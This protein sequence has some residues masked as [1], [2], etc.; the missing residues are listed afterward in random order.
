[1]QGITEVTTAGSRA[2][3]SE[4]T[5]VPADDPAQASWFLG[6][7]LNAHSI[8]GVEELRHLVDQRLSGTQARVARAEAELA[9]QL[10][11]ELDGH[12]RAADEE[13]IEQT[14][15]LRLAAGLPL[16][17]E[18]RVGRLRQQT[19]DLRAVSS[20]RAEADGAVAE[21]ER[22]LQQ[23]A[24]GAPLTADVE[25][26]REASH[27]IA[28]AE[29]AA[30]AAQA[31]LGTA[32]KGVRPEQRI[33]LRAAGKRAYQADLRYKKALAETKPLAA[34]AVALVVVAAAAVVAGA[35]GAIALPAAG[36]LSGVLLLLAV[37]ARLQRRAVVHPARRTCAEAETTARTLGEE[38]REREDVFGDW[39]VRVMKSM[40]ADDAL[41]AALQR[42]EAAAG[43]EVDPEQVEHLVAAVAALDEARARR[44]RAA[45]DEG[46]CH[47]GWLETVAALGISTEPALEP[48]PTLELAERSLA[49]RS[50]TTDRLPQL[51]EAER[52]LSARM[53][54]D[55]LLRGRALDDL[56]HD[57]KVLT[58]EVADGDGG[59]GALLYIDQDTLGPDERVDL[60]Q[61]ARRLGPEGRFVVVTRD[62]SEWSVAHSAVQRAHGDES[63]SGHE[64]EIDLRDHGSSTRTTRD[65]RPWFAS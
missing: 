1:V 49:L 18:L 11:T 16:D 42:W 9:R 3:T 5:I 17:A 26:L 27:D 22:R 32:A 56:E 7:R 20:L 61:E 44:G 64:P 21:A 45:E 41:R 54:L 25:V 46:Q 48:G 50:V 8:G 12:D 47:A 37:G 34:A 4:V 58:A 36:A 40:A 60:L 6:S 29:A 65:S 28:M 52:R 55:G 63:E 33:E 19:H 39:G 53:R 15:A 31:D 23:L 62:P 13:L 35:A 14:A 38:L 2:L 30:Q 43:R 59:D 57:A 24:P 51:D 10:V